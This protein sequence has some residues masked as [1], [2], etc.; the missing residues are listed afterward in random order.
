[1]NKI[2]KELLETLLYPRP[3][4]KLAIETGTHQGEGAETF[5]KYFDKVYTVELSDTLFNAAVKRFKNTNVIPLLGKSNEV[6]KSLIP[7]IKDKYFLFLD[8]HG[9]GEDTTF[10]PLVGRYGSPVLNE[11]RSCLGNIP[12]TIVIDDLCYFYELKDYPRPE[13]ITEEVKKLGTYSSRIISKYNGWLIFER[14]L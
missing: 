8:A 13:I 2:T 11:I 3:E 12:E 6:L 5:S 9:S 14:I 10:D 7:T 1:M 4:V